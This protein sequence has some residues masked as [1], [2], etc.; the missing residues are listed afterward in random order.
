MT[1]PPRRHT[2]WKTRLVDYLGRVAPLPFTYGQHDCALFT[3]GAIEAMTGMDPGAPFRGRYETLR[4]GIR[5]VRRAGFR[6]H[7][8][9]I[10]GLFDEIGPVFAQAGDVAVVDGLDGP[11]LGIVQGEFIYALSPDRL[12][13]LPL[14]SARRAFRVG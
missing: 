8:A 10:A 4:G 11:A 5:V 1:A 13:L 9:I 6:D 14:L 12:D 3:M 2:D 7:V